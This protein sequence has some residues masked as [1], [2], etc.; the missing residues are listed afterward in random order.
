MLEGPGQRRV[1][2]QIAQR[3]RKPFGLNQCRA[4]DATARAD[5]RVAGAHEHGGIHVQVE[6]SQQN[7]EA[8]LAIADDGTGFAEDSTVGTGLS[9]VRAL[10]R[11]ELR[12]TLD[13]SSVGPASR[14]SRLLADY[15]ARVV[16]VGPTAKRGGV[17]IRPPFHSYGAGRSLERFQ[18]DL[19]APAGR[20]AF[21]KLAAT[22]DVLI[23]SYRPG[24][25]AR[26]GIA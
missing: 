8:V 17:Q 18:V 7:G 6:L 13:L 25:T 14:A 9:I 10:V 2:E 1:V 5:D 19:K 15:G 11:D 21:L 3:E 4:V 12:G 23:E 26:L 22:A 16:K 20:D 24:V